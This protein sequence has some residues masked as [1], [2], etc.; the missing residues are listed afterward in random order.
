MFLKL[1]DGV[2]QMTQNT[3]FFVTYTPGNE[4]KVFLPDKRFQPSL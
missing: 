2:S 1:A 4:A 3:F